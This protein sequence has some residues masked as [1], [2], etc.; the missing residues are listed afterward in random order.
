M[1]KLPAELGLRSKPKNLAELASLRSVKQR[2]PSNSVARR[3]LAELRN[4]DVS[5][6]I[7]L[8]VRFAIFPDRRHLAGELPER[9]V[10][11]LPA[12]SLDSKKKT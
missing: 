8:L 9:I 10:K 5:P 2:L 4:L 11:E 6:L 12:L 3:G 1:H 7:R